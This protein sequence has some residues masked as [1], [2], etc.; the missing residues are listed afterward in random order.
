MYD[1][2]FV[3]S[4]DGDGLTFEQIN[5]TGEAFVQG[6]YTA[7]LG[8]GAEGSYPFEI[9]GVKN[10]FFGKP[11]SI[12]TEDGGYRGT[13]MFFSDGGFMGFY[14]G[15]SEYEIIQVTDNILKVR[16]VQTNFTIHAWYHIFTTVKPIEE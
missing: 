10:V 15:T 4:I 2:E 14:A 8:L 1:G 6:K 11:N 16:L 12:A 13:S 5:P 9:T 3:F 7:E